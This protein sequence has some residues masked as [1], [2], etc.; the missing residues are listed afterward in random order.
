[1][2]LCS[3]F[4]L[5]LLSSCHN[6]DEDEKAFPSRVVI[7]Y[8]AGDN[9]LSCEVQEKIDALT[10]GFLA[11]GETSDK[12]IIYADSKNA[13]PVLFEVSNARNTLNNIGW[14][15]TYPNAN[16]ASQEVV[17]QVLKEAIETFP[18][19]SYGLIVFSH[20]SAWLPAGGLE[21]PYKV[22]TRTVMTDNKDEMELTDFVSALPLPNGDKF[23]FILF[24]NC[25]MGSVE[26][27]YELKESTD[28]L[29][30]SA[31]EIVT[32]GMTGVYPL[33]LKYLYQPTPGLDAFARTYFDCWNAKEGDY[34]SATIS[35]V[36]TDKLD[37]LA[38]VSRAALL[39]WKVPGQLDDYQHFNRN[40]WHL[41]FDLKEIL[42]VAN[43]DIHTWLEEVLSE[44][45]TYQAS[46]PYF[47]KSGYLGFP[48][49]QHCGLTT[50]LMQSSYPYLNEEYRKLKWYKEVVSFSQP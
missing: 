30:A 48:I 15:H 14:I 17:H 36:Q 24:E 39:D 46:T 20:G 19:Q 18:A 7:A 23:K 37:E 29:V 38:K 3:F 40:P 6:R 12:L 21:H 9:N 8:I 47:F 43:P 4:L 26:V 35:V 31:A 13:N 45:V 42:L 32:D 10:K 2:W 22:N 5:L 49:R 44:V 25:Y 41:F 34:R 33:A 1:M 28:A 16:S 27:A 50:Y 11:L